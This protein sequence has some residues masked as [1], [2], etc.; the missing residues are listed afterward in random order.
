ML[1]V[2]VPLTHTNSYFFHFMTNFLDEFLLISGD[3]LV[4]VK[5]YLCCKTRPVLAAIS[6]PISTIFNATVFFKTQL[7]NSQCKPWDKPQMSIKM[8][9]KL[10]CVLRI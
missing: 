5:P 7:K 1:S 6:C 8:S 2:V 4:I 9:K 10:L 3:L